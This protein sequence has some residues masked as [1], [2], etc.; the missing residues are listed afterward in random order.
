M[1]VIFNDW[2]LWLPPQLS[3]CQA[4]ALVMSDEILLLIIVCIAWPWQVRCGYQ[5]VGLLACHR[6]TS[7]SR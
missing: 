4:E 1:C 3:I 6:Y 2:T 5:S 7:A